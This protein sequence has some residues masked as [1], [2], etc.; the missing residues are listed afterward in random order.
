VFLRRNVS[1][2]AGA[3]VVPAT[4]P[5]VAEGS[6]GG[7]NSELGFCGMSGKSGGRIGGLTGGGSGEGL[8]LSSLGMA[9][10]LREIR[11]G[12]PKRRHIEFRS[13]D[14]GVAPGSESTQNPTPAIKCDVGSNSSISDT[15]A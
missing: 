11:L 3:G 14:V 12:P 7:C 2:S 8:S 10:V 15:R 9:L 1:G 5:G 6:E 13:G 4:L